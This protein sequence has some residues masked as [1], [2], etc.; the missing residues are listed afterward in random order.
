MLETIERRRKNSSIR[1]NS[2]QFK[3]FPI[4]TNKMYLQLKLDYSNKNKYGNAL[5]NPIPIISTLKP[6]NPQSGIRLVRLIRV[7]TNSISL[8]LNTNQLF[9]IGHFQQGFFYI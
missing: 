1:S 9:L 6:I 7:N 4:K 8:N 5:L 2:I 3:T